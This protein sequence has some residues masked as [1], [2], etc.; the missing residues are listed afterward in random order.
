V[1][2]KSSWA[3]GV[4]RNMVSYEPKNGEVMASGGCFVADF[5]WW[6]RGISGFTHPSL[7]ILLPPPWVSAYQHARHII[8]GINKHFPEGSDSAHAE[9]YEVIWF[10]N[11]VSQCDAS[12]MDCPALLSAYW[13]G[14]AADLKKLVASQ[15]RANSRKKK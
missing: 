2:K 15:R 14:V 4:K 8:L 12:G 6:S 9:R 5:Y 7:A 11:T 1:W 3:N 13:A 10:D